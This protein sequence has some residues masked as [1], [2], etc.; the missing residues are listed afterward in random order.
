MSRSR[1]LRITSTPHDSLWVE[2]GDK[3]EEEW[4]SAAL[5]AL[6]AETG[7][8]LYSNCGQKKGVTKEGKIW[9][10]TWGKDD[11]LGGCLSDEVS[12]G[13]APLRCPRWWLVRACRRSYECLH[14]RHATRVRDAGARKWARYC[15]RHGRHTAGGAAQLVPRL[16]GSWGTKEETEVNGQSVNEQVRG[17]R[18]AV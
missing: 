10:E 6:N 16:A 7:E 15:G 13:G 14:G 17:A 8:R 11:L 18:V 1:R 12:G 3:W 9:S 2:Q 5:N 4:E